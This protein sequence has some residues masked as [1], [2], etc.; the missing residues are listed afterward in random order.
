M[1]AQINFMEDRIP[2]IEKQIKT[3]QD[4]LKSTPAGS[5]R[6]AKQAA[7]DKANRMLARSKDNLVKYK[8]ALT[9]Y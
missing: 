7:L 9:E 2:S 6:D 3:L 1:Q 4:E 8:K 5:A